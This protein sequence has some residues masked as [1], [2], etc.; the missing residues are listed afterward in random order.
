M[1]S[2]NKCKKSKIYTSI[3]IST[4]LFVNIYWGNKLRPVVWLPILW[5]NSGMATST[6]SRWNKWYSACSATAGIRLNWLATE[7]DSW[8][9]QPKK[10]KSPFFFLNRNNASSKL[11]GIYRALCR[12]CMKAINISEINFVV[13]QVFNY[14]FSLLIYNPFVWFTQLQNG[15]SFALE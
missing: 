10:K 5:Y 12:F 2:S 15:D 8:V 9:K 14:K 4:Q 6:L 11:N 1:F 3:Q 13:V 7:Y